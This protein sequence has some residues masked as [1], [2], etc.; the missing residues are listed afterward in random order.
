[1]LGTLCGMGIPMGLQYSITAIGSVVLQTAVN[2]LGSMAVAA[3]STGSKVSMF[4]CCPFDALGGTMATYAGQNVGAK[5]LDRVKEGL[6]AAILIGIIY[7]VIAFVILFFGGK[8][9]ALLF[10]DANQTE[11]IGR[12]AMF[13][14]GNSMFYIP[15]TFVNVV[16][17]TIQGM[18][19]PHSRSSRVS[20]RWRRDL[21]WASASFR[22]SASFRHALQAVSVDLRGC[23]PD[24]G[25]L[26][27]YEK[28]KSSFRGSCIIVRERTILEDAAAENVRGLKT[29]LGGTKKWQ[30]TAMIWTTT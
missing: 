5:K 28:I 1:M 9:I 3:V 17:F 15:L 26:P 20:A 10:M 8:Y 6:K 21:S 25:V 11:I 23:F 24:P 18:D 2:S 30:E 27:L 7:S 4:F 29:T 12:V 13:L 19:S 16:R 22:Y 14:I